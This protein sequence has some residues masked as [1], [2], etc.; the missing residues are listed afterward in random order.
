MAILIEV[1]LVPY[2]V[3]AAYAVTVWK[4]DTILSSILI[5][6][7]VMSTIR[8]VR[9]FRLKL[10][11]RP[12]QQQV[13]IKS[14]LRSGLTSLTTYVIIIGA[15]YIITLPPF[16]LDMIFYTLLFHTVYSL[17]CT[18]IL[19]LAIQNLMWFFVRFLER[20]NNRLNQ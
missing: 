9:A 6:H 12:A 8:E 10:R 14:V 15:S 17:L 3:M 13:I 16:L 7:S 1:I 5:M 19:G 20:F 11:N 2:L 18:N 4:T